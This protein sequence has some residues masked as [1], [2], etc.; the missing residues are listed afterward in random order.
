MSLRRFLTPSTF[1]SISKSGMSGRS[2][3][4]RRLAI[5]AP[6]SPATV[7]P[8]AKFVPSSRLRSVNAVVP[9]PTPAPTR[10]RSLTGA[11]TVSYSLPLP[12]LTRKPIKGI[13]P[14]KG[15]HHNHLP[16]GA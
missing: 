2:G 12:F 10:S 7:A 5:A 13:I 1:L 9:P 15:N 6:P 14:N 16:L 3:C 4:L 11:V 8:A